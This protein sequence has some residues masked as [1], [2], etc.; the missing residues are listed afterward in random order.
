MKPSIAAR[1]A[2]GSG[3][4]KAGPSR[5]TMTGTVTITAFAA[6]ATPSAVSRRTRLS[7]QS[8]RVTGLASA[9]GRSLASRAR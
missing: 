6:Y 5:S 3:G 9:I 8:M 1:T 7:D 2:F 4:E